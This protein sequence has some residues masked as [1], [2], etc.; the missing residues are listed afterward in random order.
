MTEKPSEFDLH[1]YVDDQLDVGQRFAV[2][3]HLAENPALAAHVMGELSNRTGL[4]L[5][6]SDAG[7][8]PSAILQQAEAIQ[9]R[10]P[11]SFWR[12]MV[13]LGG[14][15]ALAA[16]LSALFIPPG[17]PDYVDMAV[18]SH[19]VAMMR[20]HM[21]SQME[22]V[23]LDHREILKRTRID[24]PSLPADWHV[25]DVQLFPTGG[26]PALLVAV[27]TAEGRNLSIFALRERSAAPEIPD[28][29]REGYES[30]AYWR[31][32]DMSYALTGEED[33]GI[34]DKAAEGLNRL[35]S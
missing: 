2:E 25:T 33:P 26:S 13:P 10:S 32:G 34:M 8:V 29:V 7:P 28:A 30:V 35:W 15:V 9:E 21:A 3:A 16:A 23:A 6:A 12:K 4:R 27:K 14:G 5:L 24:L 1:A 20:A 18:A 11:R 31:R 22:T 19:R 17:R